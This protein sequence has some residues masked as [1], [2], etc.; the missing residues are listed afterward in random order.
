VISFKILSRDPRSQARSGTLRT[1]HG[2]VHTPNFMPVATQASV[3]GIAPS[4]LKKLG[5]EILISNTYHLILRPSSALIRDLGGLHS[6]MNWDRTIVTDSG[7]FQAYSLDQLR[8]VNDKGIEFSSHLDGS[9]YELTPEKAVAVQEDLDSDIAM[10]LDFFTPYP[11]AFLDARLAV[12]RTVHW[13]E[14]SCAVKKKQPLFGIVQGASYKDLRIECAERLTRLPFD[15]YGIG[16]L[17][18]G[19]P[20]FTTNEMVTVT[21]RILPHNRARYL[22]GCGYPEDI[23]EAVEQGVDLFDCVLPTRNGRTGMAFTSQGKVIIKASRYARDTAPLDS[24]CHCSTCRCFSRAYIRHLF[25]AGELLAGRLVSYHNIH[26][27][28][29]LM[30]GI[31]QSIEQGTFQDFKKK[32]SKH[33]DFRDMAAFPSQ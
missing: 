18:I 2:I 29:R 20:A 25:N 13:A 11:S 4:D 3:K 26:F 15:G 32:V 16:G 19:E 24:Q 8:R 6:F 17:M 12:E 28:M 22:M 14:R 27:F 30:A 1:A 7:G 9:Q 5:V 33:F 10:V 21:T 23:L 31:R